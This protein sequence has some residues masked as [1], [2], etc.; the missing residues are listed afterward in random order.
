MKEE[1]ILTVAIIVCFIIAWW[2]H[3]TEKE[4]GWRSEN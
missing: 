3:K 1:L 2:L 4:L